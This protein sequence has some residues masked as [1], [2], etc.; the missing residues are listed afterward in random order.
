[1]ASDLELMLEAERRGIGLPPDKQALLDEG[2]KRGIVQGPVE[3]PQQ[4]AVTRRPEDVELGPEY[5]ADPLAGSRPAPPP[6]IAEPPPP[7]TAPAP[8]QLSGQEEAAFQ[9]WYANWAQ[10]TGI[11]PN[12]DDPLHRYD[13]RAAYKAGVEPQID[14]SDQKY[15]W[16][17]RFKAPDHPNRFVGGIDTRTGEPAPGAPP[18]KLQPFSTFGEAV[19]QGLATKPAM[20]L[21]GSTAFTPGQGL[22][23]DQLSQKASTFLE[24]LRR[25]EKQAELQRKAAGRLWPVEEGEKWYQISSQRIPEAVNA[26]AANIGDHIPLML[27]TIGG[28]LLGKG[29]GKLAGSG[30]G[31]LAGLAT[32]G[33]DPTDIATVPVIATATEKIIEHLGGAAPLIAIEAGNFL[34]NAKQVGVPF[35]IAEKYA[36]AYGV[37]SGAIEYAQ[38][39]WN[40]KAFKR[41]TAPVQKKILFRVL[42]EIGGNVFEGVEELSQEGLQNA[43]VGKAIDEAKAR[44]PNFK[45]EKPDTWEGAGRS[46]ALGA[47]ISV[48]TRGVGH[49]SQVLRSKL[50]PEQESDI[51]AAA[52]QVAQTEGERPPPVPGEVAPEVVPEI[53]PEIAPPAPEA[54]APE[55]PPEVAET[56][57][58]L[59]DLQLDL[60]ETFDKELAKDEEGN[61]TQFTVV[62]SPL[63]DQSE[64][65]E[66]AAEVL[67]KEIVWFK[68]NDRSKI[69]INGSITE[70]TI[71]LDVDSKK[72]FVATVVHEAAH[73]ME[74]AAPEL[75]KKL[76]E[77]VQQEGTGFD[78]YKAELKSQYEKQGLKIDEKNDTWFWN[79]LIG[80]VMDERGTDPGFWRNLYEKSPEAVQKFVDTVNEIIEAIKGTAVEDIDIKQF[81]ADFEKV[82]QVASDVM[83]EY[84]AKER[85]AAPKQKP[86]QPKGEGWTWVPQGQAIEPGQEIRA[87]LSGKYDQGAWVRPEVK[88]EE[89]PKAPEAQRAPQ[90]KP[91]PATEAPA[92]E[93]SQKAKEVKRPKYVSQHEWEVMQRDLPG[94]ATRYVVKAH[95]E[96][97]KSFGI[98][99][100]QTKQFVPSKTFGMKP[101]SRSNAKRDAFRLNT[102]YAE[103]VNPFREIFEARRRETM[104]KHK[105]RPKKEK[106]LTVHGIIRLLGR[107]KPLSEEDKGLPRTVTSKKSGRGID[108]VLKE[109][110]ESYP[111]FIGPEVTVDQFRDMILGE[112]R[113]IGVAEDRPPTAEEIEKET[114][115][116]YKDIGEAMELEGRT[117][118]HPISIEDGDL[119]AYEDKGVWH[120]R[121]PGAEKW[122][123]LDPT[124]ES[125]QEVLKGIQ[126]QITPEEIPFSISR[127]FEAELDALEGVQKPA[128]EKVRKKKHRW[129]GRVERGETATHWQNQ[130]QKMYQQ[131]YYIPKSRKENLNKAAAYMDKVGEEEARAAYLEGRLPISG[132]EQQGVAYLLTEHYATQEQT[133]ETIRI[134]SQLK[135]RFAEVNLEHGRAI[136][137][138]KEWGKDL[139]RRAIAFAKGQEAVEK[140]NEIKLGPRAGIVEKMQAVIDDLRTKF[141]AAALEAKDIKAQLQEEREKTSRQARIKE[142]LWQDRLATATKRNRLAGV[143]E[144][145]KAQMEAAQAEAAE[146]PSISITRGEPALAIERGKLSEA[147]FT[148]IMLEVAYRLATT[149]TKKRKRV[150][151]GQVKSDLLLEM[152]KKHG[153]AVGEEWVYILEAAGEHVANEIEYEEQQRGKRAPKKP[154]APVTAEGK[155]V[156]TLDQTGLEEWAQLQGLSPETGLQAWEAVKDE[157]DI[158]KAK[159]ELVEW[160][161]RNKDKVSEAALKALRETEWQSLEA[162]EKAALLKPAPPKAEPTETE[163]RRRAAGQIKR[164]GLISYTL[165]GFDLNLR[166]VVLQH[167]KDQEATLAKLK[168]RIIGVG[169]SPADA[170][171]LAAAIDKEFKA[172]VD[173]RAMKLVDDFFTREKLPARSLKDTKAISELL[174]LLKTGALTTDKH[175]DAFAKVYDLKKMTPEMANRLNELSDEIQKAPAGTQKEDATRR[176][177]TYIAKKVGINTAEQYWSLWYSSLLSGHQTHQRNII[178]TFFNSTME[179]MLDMARRPKA[180]PMVLMRLPFNIHKAVV[181]AVYHVRTGLGEV[182]GE[183]K[184]E[185]PAVLEMNPFQKAARFLNSMKYVMRLM[186]AEDM[187]FFKPAQ[188]AHAI[189]AAYDI[190]RD[191]GLS[192]RALSKRV[193]EML[194]FDAVSEAQYKA[195]AE[196]EGLKGLE[197]KRRVFELIEQ[198]RDQGIMEEAFNFGKRAT[199]NYQAEGILGIGAKA[200]QNASKNIPAIRLIVPFTN[201]VANVTNM[202]LDYTPWGF[203][204]V[205]RGMKLKKGEYR[206]FSVESGER[207]RHTAKAVLGTT[208]MAAVYMLSKM[209]EDDDDPL[210]RLHGQGP[211]DRTKKNQ[212][213]ETGWKPYT[214]QIRGKYY[215]YLYTPMAIPFSIM[216]GFMDAGRYTKLGEQELSTRLAYALMQPASTITDMSFLSGVSGLF[217]VLSEKD[218]IRQARMGERLMSR[219]GTTFVPNFARQVY[220]IYDPTLYDA[221]SWQE[222]IVREI[223]VIGA[224]MLKPRLNMLGEVIK[225]DRGIL[226]GKRK[227]D[228]VWQLLAEKNATIS[229]PPKTTEVAGEPMTRD[230]YYDYIKMS[231][232]AIRKEI[233]AELPDL[234]KMDKAEAQEYIKDIVSVAREDARFT[235]WDRREQGQ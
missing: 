224:H 44:D 39:L 191:E 86:P 32:G 101:T 149:Q 9:S 36:R 113:G 228:A 155:V 230:E 139:G 160:A 92:P 105:R 14:P 193:G 55:V 131:N 196:A 31:A 57:P 114:E 209:Y 194:H 220:R 167:Y 59:D 117:P 179:V 176:L 195:Q 108:V 201:I 116:Y 97:S 144:R 147:K 80:E 192:G 207:A 104:K 180:A 68:N 142:K 95:P 231:G 10:K 154:K 187:L 120:V 46:F 141:S 29:A 174:T 13:Y 233:E 190:A 85:E 162:A 7:P 56:Q 218:P 23:I 84:T 235:L 202:S 112:E 43:M 58:L 169:L 38:V 126:D 168:E 67:G 76:L 122:L 16:D 65:A 125:H 150:N 227:E 136:D 18:A 94:H 115:A 27:L 88:A 203:Y 145:L 204:R 161:G 118:E 75:H 103:S 186:I 79:E 109:A 70:D 183:H 87:D 198:N 52:E 54:V 211:S 66:E 123:A 217:G 20:A 121:R 5:I 163:K 93:V 212:M 173:Q 135:E 74:K 78:E 37:G 197:A 22:G 213:Y 72:P 89:K 178:S 1:V 26:W 170:A 164:E 111:D 25:P 127:D 229:V 210:F 106:A 102:E 156:Q 6:G 222:S 24:S 124:K 182:R 185:T 34:D 81:F 166:N 221:R 110:Q 64:A 100:R 77:I 158:E 215:S 146:A 199:F 165:R 189:I 225:P 172:Q 15:H 21:R 234:K 96:D 134:L 3:A 51:D 143:A 206:K 91:Q 140:F 33:P 219:I 90:E 175:F 19:I 184:F 223:P 2:R 83:A 177:L 4:L 12:P 152:T 50:T 171:K 42:K 47:G 188:E 40:L 200:I 148:Q 157:A 138:L 28:K 232:R 99:D 73:R 8:T 107:I 205:V 208:A 133:E 71:Y 181:E 48:I 130:A 137:M 45:A 214:I 41:L 53:A 132:E 226:L 61:P 129:S 63:T 62:E 69:A 82:G 151:W 35:D 30:V 11:N 49:A 153:R 159:L 119:Q 17:S 128:E 60:E 216:G 98:Y